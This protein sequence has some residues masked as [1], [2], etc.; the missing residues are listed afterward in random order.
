MANTTAQTQNAYAAASS[1]AVH[2]LEAAVS[3]ASSG[4]FR[5]NL[6]GAETTLATTQK[7][8]IRAPFAF[9]VT[10]VRASVF[11]V[12]SSGLPTFDVNKAGTSILSTKLTIDVS[13]KTSTTAATPYVFGGATA[14]FA[15][16]D[17]LSIDVDV[18]GTGAT[19]GVVLVYYVRD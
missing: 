19:G 18:A 3:L 2:P 6:G 1:I 8:N 14:I 13:E 11:T 16:D 7:A 12:S 5:L 10:D 15:D 17:E 9:T 4:V